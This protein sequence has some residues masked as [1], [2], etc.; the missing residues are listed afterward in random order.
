MLIEILTSI[1]EDDFYLLFLFISGFV[2][3][4]SLCLLL[5]GVLVTFGFSAIV[6][7]V[8]DSQVVLKPGGNRIKKTFFQCYEL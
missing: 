2:I 4:F 1:V 7:L 6:N 3:A 5:L 8:I